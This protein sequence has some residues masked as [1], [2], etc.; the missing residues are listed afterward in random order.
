MGPIASCLCIHTNPPLTSVAST[1]P[2][3]VLPIKSFANKG[4][5]SVGQ[6]FNSPEIPQMAKFPLVIVNKLLKS[7]PV[8]GVSFF[9]P[10]NFILTPPDLVDCE[11]IGAF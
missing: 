7:A 4:E 11:A 3:S 10:S 2:D 5:P 9:A 8:V 6:A 1:I